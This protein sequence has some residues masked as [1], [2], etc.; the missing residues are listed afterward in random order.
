MAAEVVQLVQDAVIWELLVHDTTGLTNMLA[1]LRPHGN[2]LE[3]LG[4][5]IDG[6]MARVVDDQVTLIYLQLDMLVD[7]GMLFELLGHLLVLLLEL[8][9]PGQLSLDLSVHAN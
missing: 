1:C 3:T 7:L 8:I 2:M 9:V 4:I 6:D 5:V